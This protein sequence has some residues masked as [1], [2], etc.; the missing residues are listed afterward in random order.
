ME[1]M[2][3]IYDKNFENECHSVCK[4]MISKI[5]NFIKPTVSLYND[6]CSIL[7]QLVP[8]N[9]HSINMLFDVNNT[10]QLTYQIAGYM[11][12]CYCLIQYYNKLTNCNE[13]FCSISHHGYSDYLCKHTHMFPNK[14]G[15]PPVSWVTPDCQ[16]SIPYNFPVKTKTQKKKHTKFTNIIPFYF[17]SDTYR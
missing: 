5:C 14:H 17:D 13:C 6:T 16:I 9:L 11:Y 7:T 15:Q 12:V 4:L 1:L 3:F 2:T 10:K 8:I